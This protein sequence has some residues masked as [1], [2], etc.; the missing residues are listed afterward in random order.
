MHCFKTIFTRVCAL[1]VTVSTRDSTFVRLKRDTNFSCGRTFVRRICDTILSCGSTFVQLSCD[2]ILICGS[3]FVRLNS[4]PSGAC[5]WSR[6]LIRRLVVIDG[7]CSWSSTMFELN[8]QT[9]QLRNEF[10]AIETV[11]ACRMRQ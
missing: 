10:V 1:A 5:D 11:A 6:P 9:P 7:A 2:T 8:G 3:I 4:D